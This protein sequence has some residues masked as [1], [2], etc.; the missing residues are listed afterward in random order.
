MATHPFIY[1]L[2]TFATLTL[3]AASL[4]SSQLVVCEPGTVQ[5][6]LYF[7]HTSYQ[8]ASTERDT[9]SLPKMVISTSYEGDK[10][11]DSNIGLYGKISFALLVSASYLLL[12][13]LVSRTA[14]ANMFD[15]KFLD[16]H[17]D[18]MFAIF[19]F[20]AAI[21]AAAL[22]QVMV[23]AAES[24]STADINIIKAGISNDHV[25]SITSCTLGHAG[26]Y[27]WAGAGLWGAMMIFAAREARMSV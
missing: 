2:A 8:I 24:L 1:L 27:A 4:F 19:T 5:K 21:T 15:I 25:K 3:F 20:C 17:N 13:T 18:K 11:F 16:Q 12:F 23:T 22:I 7:T 6:N 10:N 26:Y 9:I 14:R